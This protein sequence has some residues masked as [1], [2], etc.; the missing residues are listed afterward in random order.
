MS[1]AG[2][3]SDSEEEFVLPPG[4]ESVK[5]GSISK[6]SLED[7]EL[8]FFRV[9][10]NVDASVLH[11]VTIKLPKD[12]N[13]FVQVPVDVEGN[14]KQFT[15]KSNDISLYSQVVNLVPDKANSQ[16]FVPGKPFARSFSLVESVVVPNVPAESVAAAAPNDGGS[17]AKKKSKKSKKHKT[18]E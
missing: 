5:G 11:G 1:D 3:G 13:A 4:F 14:K 12:Q 18:T 16:T 6:A 15:L 9:P 10:K 2:S 17:P 8:W 7:K